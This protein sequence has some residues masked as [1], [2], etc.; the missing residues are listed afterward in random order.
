MKLLVI[1]SMSETATANYF[2]A[3]FKR[4]GHVLLVCSDIDG[5]Q[6]D[7]VV[8]GLVDAEAI[9]RKRAFAANVVL[10]FEGGSMGLLP[11]I[12]KVN[13][14]LT[15]WYG[16]DTHM[17]YQK[18]L[19]IG[20]L[21][22]VTFIAQKEYVE[23]LRNDGLRQVYWLPLGFA[24]ELMPDE[25]PERTMDIA[26]V[27]SSHIQA[28][29]KRHALIAAMRSEFPLT[30]FGEATPKRMGV[31][32][33]SAH[34]V[35]NKSVKNDVNMRFFEAT[36]AGAVLVTDPIV[37]NGI[38]ELFEENDHYVVYR[39][40][41]S[42]LKIVRC[43]LA[44]PARCAAI[45]A[46]ARQRVLERHTYRHRADAMLQLVANSSQVAAP[47]QEDYFAACLSLNLLSGALDAAA[48]SFALSKAGL[49]RRYLGKFLF[50]TL[51]ILALIVSL[52]ERVRSL[53]R[54]KT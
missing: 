27:G 3:A 38:E 23:K 13:S 7:M 53:N 11:S 20:R 46:R 47:R 54:S 52:I 16:I 26:H 14:Y 50:Y 51:K 22:D 5:P 25:M 39:D 2:I 4:A 18:H 6:V 8:S 30:Y 28:N 37:A 45:G 9:L 32:Y 44:D 19:L 40:E 36:G 21:F 34:V 24:P 49:Y 15:A 17:D 35:F 1:A 48:N 42:L 12:A 43:L 10:Y 41:A 31:L 33:A 29:P